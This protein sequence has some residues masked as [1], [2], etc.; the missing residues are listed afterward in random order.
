MGSMQLED[1][2]PL[3]MCRLLAYVAPQPLSLHD[4]VQDATFTAFR[5]LSRIHDDGW[6]MA[7]V[8]DP[9][10]DDGIVVRRSVTRAVDDPQFVAAATEIRARAGFA[11]LRWASDGLAVMPRNTHPFTA[12]GWAFAH[13]GF[14][15]GSDVIEKLLEDRHRRALT[16]TTDSERYF[17]LVL[18]CA[19]HTGDMIGGVQQAATLINELSG[20]VSINAM[21]LSSSRLLA[22]QGLTGA[23]PPLDDL[24]AKVEHPDQLPID[25]LDGYFRLARRANDAGL[26]IASSGMPR[27]DWAEVA[28]NT[29]MDVDV[30]TGEWRLHPL[31]EATLSTAASAQ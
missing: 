11:H 29:V 23:T 19:E 3:D 1:W 14:V 12:G 2:W 5:N 20:A 26:V 10:A 16:G 25:H 31:L 17:R 22:V 13:N 28:P 4:A 27:D 21:L 8:G 30:M 6:G 9:A 15:R 7:W 24:L 18:Q